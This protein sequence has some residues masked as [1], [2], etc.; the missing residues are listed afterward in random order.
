MSLQF[1]FD[2][3]LVAGGAVATHQFA[4]ESCKEE[5]HAQHQEEHREVEPHTVG[6][7]NASSHP[8][9]DYH[10]KREE[11]KEPGDAAHSS[12]EMH[13]LFAELV[14]KPQRKQV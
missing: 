2:E 9:D 10:Y 12:K 7:S 5:H 11:S 13:R 14:E 6:Q 3:I 4:D 1:F 8:E